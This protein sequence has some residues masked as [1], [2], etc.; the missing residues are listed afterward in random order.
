MSVGRRERRTTLL[1]LLL[2]GRGE[3]GTVI[4]HRRVVMVGD[5]EAAG[6]GSGCRGRRAQTARSRRGVVLVVLRQHHPRGT[7]RRLLVKLANCRRAGRRRR[8]AAQSERVTRHSFDN[9][10]RLMGVGHLKK[11]TVTQRFAFISRPAS[12]GGAGART[13]PTCSLRFRATECDWAGQARPRAGGQQRAQT[14]RHRDGD[15]RRRLLIRHISYELLVPHTPLERDNSV[16][17]RVT[18]PPTAAAG[19]GGS[20]SRRSVK[21]A[22]ILTY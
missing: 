15:W 7:G 19:G 14:T 20:G 18:S 17:L 22:P 16:P 1:L 2:E 12:V 11:C 3:R 6:H 9:G 10:V 21:R 4:G 5:A 8:S 13:V